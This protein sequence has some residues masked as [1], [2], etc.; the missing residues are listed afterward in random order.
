MFD[1]FKISKITLSISLI[2]PFLTSEKVVHFFC[3][4]EDFNCNFYIWIKQWYWIFINI[5][6]HKTIKIPQKWYKSFKNQ[7]VWFVH[8]QFQNF[9]NSYMYCSTWETWQKENNK[10]QLYLVTFLEQTALINKVELFFNKLEITLFK[11]FY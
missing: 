8:I 11:W 6:I 1:I 9:S 3:C 7:T 5:K 10:L 2:N 4:W